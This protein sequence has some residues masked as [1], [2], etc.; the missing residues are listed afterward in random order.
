M[1]LMSP[2][3]RWRPSRAGQ[4]LLGSDGAIKLADFGIST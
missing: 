4:V 1:R 3:P 2:G